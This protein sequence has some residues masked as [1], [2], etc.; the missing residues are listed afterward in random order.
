MKNQ[1]KVP[2]TNNKF[3]NN[4]EKFNLK[5]LKDLNMGFLIRAG[6]LLNNFIIN[7]PKWPL[8]S[9]NQNKLQNEDFKKVT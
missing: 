8:N 9:N 7:F 3:N 6:K 1:F 5:L 2:K 4:R